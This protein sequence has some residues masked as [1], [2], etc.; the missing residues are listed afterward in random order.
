[1]IHLL[2]PLVLGHPINNTVLVKVEFQDYGS[3]RDKSF[4][5]EKGERGEVNG[6]LASNLGKWREMRA[7]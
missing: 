1:M 2:K 5:E 6:K 3:P 4:A 7:T